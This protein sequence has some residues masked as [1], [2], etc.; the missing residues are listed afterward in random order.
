MSKTKIWSSKLRASSFL[1]IPGSHWKPKLS[2][3]KLVSQTNTRNNR[4]REKQV[5]IEPTD[6]LSINQ[7]QGVQPS[8]PSKLITDQTRET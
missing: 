3:S 4:S 7:G 1:P 8:L 5:Q 6:S 2:K